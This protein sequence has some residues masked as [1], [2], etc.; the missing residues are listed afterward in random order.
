[1]NWV[2]LLSVVWFASVIGAPLLLYRSRHHF[3]RNYHDQLVAIRH[4]VPYHA[5]H[6]H[7]WRF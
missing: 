1:M 7:H 2:S 3:R 6:H 4:G 5:R